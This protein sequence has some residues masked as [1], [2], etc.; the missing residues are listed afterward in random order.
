MAEEMLGTLLAEG[1][2]ISDELYSVPIGTYS[3]HPFTVGVIGTNTDA[4]SDISSANSANSA[5]GSITVTRNVS[6]VPGMPGAMRTN[7]RQDATGGEPGDGAATAIS[8][9][10]V[11]P[12]AQPAAQQVTASGSAEVG[13]VDGVSEVDGVGEVTV[14]PERSDE[15]N[16]QSAR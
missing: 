16:Q 1:M 13:K 12:V 10:V 6:G 11:P 5:N 14:Q 7:T 4:S 8:P 15:S 9:S 3:G 2:T